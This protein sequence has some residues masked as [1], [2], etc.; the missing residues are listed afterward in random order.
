MQQ[1]LNEEKTKKKTKNKNKGQPEPNPRLAGSP[2]SL[3]IAGSTLNPS[4]SGNPGDPN[5]KAKLPNVD[6]APKPKEKP[7]KKAK[8]LGAIDV[9]GD[10]RQ[11]SM[12]VEGYNFFQDLNYGDMAIVFNNPYYDFQLKEREEIET[13]QFNHLKE[14]RNATMARI[15]MSA[16]ETKKMEAHNAKMNQL[17]K[18]K[19]KKLADTESK[20]N[21]RIDLQDAYEFYSKFINLKPENQI[22]SRKDENLQKQAF[23]NA[24]IYFSDRYYVNDMAR[25]RP[26]RQPYSD[27]SSQSLKDFILDEIFEF[28]IFHK[29]SKRKFYTLKDDNKK[30]KI[31]GTPEDNPLAYFIQHKE[32]P[33]QSLFEKAIS[34]NEK[35]DAFKQI[36]DEESNFFFLKKP[37]DIT[38]DDQPK[39]GGE[40]ADRRTY[41]QIA[42]DQYDVYIELTVKLNDA[43]LHYYRDYMANKDKNAEKDAETKK[44]PARKAT[45][46][47][48]KRVTTVDNLSTPG[49][50]A[51][52]CKSA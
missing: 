35:H 31:G 16:K 18:D 10:Q 11:L 34:K 15:N 41:K 26:N 1:K 44:Q 39:E 36:L 30:P 40:G 48:T 49:N 25:I 9:Y 29:I 7:K 5:S 32:K 6:A 2:S 22:E 51:F 28:N 50:K 43:S 4:Q 13:Y 20:K 14:L 19:F 37:D 21:I 8:V 52:E 42:A 17:L 12:R 45:R 3:N 24:L 23:A 38:V 46:K 47:A 33:K 27:L